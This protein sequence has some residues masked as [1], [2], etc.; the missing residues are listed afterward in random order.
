MYKL[1]NFL[2]QLGKKT[3]L[4]GDFNCRSKL[5]GDK[6]SNTRGGELFEV[7]EANDMVVHNRKDV[8]TPTYVGHLGESV[9]DLVVSTSDLAAQIEMEVLHDYNMSDHRAIWFALNN[10]EIKSTERTGWGRRLVY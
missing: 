1:D 9:V 6:I 10:E 4:V 2:K 7:F 3:I 8:F 5:W